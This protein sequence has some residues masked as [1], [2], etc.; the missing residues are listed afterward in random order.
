MTAQRKIGRLSK[1]KKIYF[2]GAIPFFMLILL[3]SNLT[4]SLSSTYQDKLLETVKVQIEIIPDEK[5]TI[6]AQLAVPVKTNARNLM[7]KTFQVGYAGWGKKFITSIAGFEADRKKKQ[8]WALEIGGE[9]A[10]KGISE[11][12][13]DKPLKI[14]WKLTD[15]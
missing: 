15:Y 13:I 5:N 1:M 7:E 10:K 9:Y 6:S 14:V 8:Y 11:I 4:S 2:Y 12:T 3:Q